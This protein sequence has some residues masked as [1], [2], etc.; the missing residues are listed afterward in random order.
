[1]GCSLHLGWEWFGR[2]TEPGRGLYSFW[3]GI[4]LAIGPWIIRAACWVFK[5]ISVGQTLEIPH[6]C[7]NLKQLPQGS[8]VEQI[9]FSVW[10]WPQQMS[11]GLKGRP[12]YNVN[13][14]QQPRHTNS[15][16]TETNQSRPSG[17]VGPAEGMVSEVQLFGPVLCS[18]L[19][20]FSP[21]FPTLW[22]TLATKLSV[23]L[24]LC[25]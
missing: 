6:A 15:S 5:L 18:I 10:W 16:P 9:C 11:D 12:Q 7:C 22:T 24:A 21:A 1:M 17:T 19:C 3:G 4:L 20:N 25:I 8:C 14:T 13:N 2:P 23:V